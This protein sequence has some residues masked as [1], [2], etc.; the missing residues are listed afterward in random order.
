M[1]EK[2]A[3]SPWSQDNEFENTLFGNKLKAL[4]N[5][6]CKLCAE[7][8]VKFVLTMALDSEMKLSCHKNSTSVA[9][10]HDLA[11]K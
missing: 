4:D 6:G 2:N 8:K 5:S 11:L 9:H 10:K 3:Q 7:I 1:T